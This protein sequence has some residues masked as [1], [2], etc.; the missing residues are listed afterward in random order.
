[1][2]SWWRSKVKVTG[3]KYVPFSNLWLSG[4]FLKSSQSFKFPITGLD[5][6]GGRFEN[7]PFWLTL[8]KGQGHSGLS[9]KKFLHKNFL[10]LFFFGYG[11]KSGKNVLEGPRKIKW[12]LPNVNPP[13]T[14]SITTNIR[15]WPNFDPKQFFFDHFFGYR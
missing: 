3:V 14:F 10:R 1:M 13:S 15:F 12:T 8:V 4:E 6:Q 5:S 11:W 7:V 9:K 2:L